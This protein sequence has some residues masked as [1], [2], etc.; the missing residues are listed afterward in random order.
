MRFRDLSLLC[1]EPHRIATLAA[2]RDAF[3]SFMSRKPLDSA[4]H[5]P[6]RDERAF[7]ES[8]RRFLRIIP[9][10]IFALMAGAIATAA[11]RFLRPS[12]R[13]AEALTW[14]NVAPIAELTGDA[15]LLRRIIVQRNAGWQSASTEHSIYVLP[16]QNNRIVS[17][18]CPHENCNVSWRVEARK[19][20]CP[21][22]QSTFAE[23]GAQLTG[24]ARRGLDPLPT[25][26][27]N[28]VLQV[29]YQT[30]VNNIAERI[31]RR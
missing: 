18:E 28:G 24:P 20:F 6:K 31:V 7:V 25:R 12:T 30:F 27:Q 3:C 16:K 4:Q 21:C 10:G 1:V 23:D 11:F 2:R 26:E 22:H 17:S 8:R 5:N 14:T 15:P 13:T 9:V 19:F 29:Q